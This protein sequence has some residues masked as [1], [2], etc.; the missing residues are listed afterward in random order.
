MK[1][2]RTVA[3][4]TV[5]SLVCLLIHW[6]GFT[7]W[8][9]A[10]DFA[11]LSSFDRIHSFHDLL[12]ALFRPQA[13]G[14]IRPFSERAFFIIGYGL[15]GLDSLPF[16]MVIFA[17]QF[18]ALALV[19]L[20]GAKLTGSRA[21]G[22]C[23]ALLW[24]I[25]TASVEPLAWVCVY[26]EVMCA[27]FLLL[28]FYFLLRYVE[29]GTRPYKLWEWVVFL[30]GFGALELN[31]VY[32]AMAAA[33]TLLCARKFF[34]GTLPMMGVSVAYTV[35]H[36]LAAP[37]PSTG[38]YAMRFGASTL[39]TLAIYWTWSIGPAYLETPAHVR[40]WMLIAG[41]AAV[42]VALFGFLALRLRAGYGA[43]LFCVVWYVAALAP[44]LPL[45]D[46][47]TEYYPYIPL[48]GL[49]WLGGWGLVEVWRR[50]PGGRAAAVALAALYTAMVLPRTVSASEWN[51]RISI[52][53]R[54]L[55]EGVARAHELHPGQAILL[56]GADDEQFFNAIRHKAFP[57]IG[58][59]NVYLAP[60][61]EKH[62]AEPAGW[63]RVEDFILAPAIAARALDLGELQVYD[64][65]GKVLRN[66]TTDYGVTL[67]ESG[68]PLR[69]SAGEPLTAYLLGPEWYKLDVDH[70]WMPKR[71]TLRIGAPAE[72]GKNLY[73]SGYVPDALGAV[74]ITVTVDGA[75]LPPR[76]VRP[77]PF[78]AVFPLPDSV[79]G[80]SEMLVAVE[81]SRT[82]RPP[83]DPREL[84]LSFGVFEVW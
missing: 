59:N 75:P 19:A 54:D 6:Q 30:L 8:F 24:T 31:V 67:V 14:T 35:V 37:P 20:V 50:G 1:R 38:D 41:V 3:Y 56:Y 36:T 45:R 42:S 76:T 47:I 18:A 78:E 44:M 46:H 71:A 68:M 17:T 77:G 63:G 43:A 22:F 74:E 25:N 5:P 55:V 65:R 13:Q 82:F 73:L 40:R 62:I 16:H 9:R 52:R 80:K 48:I 27:F 28:A 29:T 7:A 53:A 72:P 66:I 83:D 33:Y 4:W 81:V 57:L 58:M 70:R 61:S 12:I 15:F 84:G 10:D 32:P 23:A 26:N 60:G 34:R 51:H 39:R 79:V 64:V 69:V 49:A 2:A 21:A 11:W